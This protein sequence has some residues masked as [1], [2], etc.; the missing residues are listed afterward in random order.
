MSLAPPMLYVNFSAPVFARCYSR[1]YQ[2]VSSRR[3][4]FQ[5][6]RCINKRVRQL[7]IKCE[8]A[9]AK[10]QEKLRRGPFYL[11]QQVHCSPVGILHVLKLG[12]GPGIASAIV[13]VCF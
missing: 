6:L 8:G 11:Q 1:I 12:R 10:H 9:F 13:A 5:S 2:S 7:R 3:D 4:K